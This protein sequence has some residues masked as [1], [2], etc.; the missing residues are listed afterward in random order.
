MSLASPTVPPIAEPAISFAPRPRCQ[1]VSRKGRACRYLGVSAK[2][3]YCKQHLPLGSTERLSDDMHKACKNFDT[4]EG[5]TNVLHSIFFALADGEISERRAGVLTYILQTILNSQR[6]NLQLQKLVAGAER[7]GLSLDNPFDPSDRSEADPGPDKLTWNLP[8]IREQMDAG[9]TSDGGAATPNSGVPLTRVAG[10]VPSG[11]PPPPPSA[12]FA[13]GTPAELADRPSPPADLNHFYP[14]DP[15]LPR[16][17]Q[18]PDRL[19]PPFPSQAELDR[20][21]AAFN[22]IRGFRRSRFVPPSSR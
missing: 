21:N 9:V 8:P 11:S 19:A 12:A 16:H 3:P 1:H 17:L 2:Q 15:T 6:S 10:E 22:P 18:D 4:P 14:R 20:R 5:V 13:E 7:Q